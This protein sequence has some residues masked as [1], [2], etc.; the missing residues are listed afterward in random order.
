VLPYG[1]ELSALRRIPTRVFGILMS[2][3]P[4]AAAIAG[5]L[6][7]GQ[8]LHTREVAA[9]FMVSAASAGVTLGQRDAGIPAQPLE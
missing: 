7:L 6:F 2:L 5:L 9:L 4:A 3:E 8:R 1:A